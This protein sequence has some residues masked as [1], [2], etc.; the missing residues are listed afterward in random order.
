[1]IAIIDYGV[2]NISAF[3]NV[4]NKLDI[5]IKVAKKPSDLEGVTKLILPGVGAFD[6][7]MNELNNSG[8]V[9]KLNELVLV[10]KLPVIGICV[11]LQMMAT[12]SDEGELPGLGWVDATVKLFDVTKFNFNTHLP[13][14]GWNDTTPVKENLLFINLEKD[15]KFYFLHSFYFE[16]NNDEDI[17]AISDYGIKFTCAINKGNIYGTQFHPEKSHHFGI[18]LLKNFAK[19]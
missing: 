12:K 4:Y 18:Q 13:H 11:G 2:G 15:S 10:D 14:M 6:H 5:S 19:L 8:M 17:I 9:D 1:M 3:V 16:C 7:A